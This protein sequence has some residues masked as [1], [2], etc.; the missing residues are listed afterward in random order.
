MPQFDTMTFFN[1]VFWLV[2]IV[3]AFYMTVVRYMLPVLAFSLKSRSKNL[4]LATTPN[5]K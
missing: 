4:K 3:F 2:S 5:S 1:Q